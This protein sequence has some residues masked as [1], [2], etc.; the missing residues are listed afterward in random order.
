V[1][2]N[3]QNDDFRKK[4]RFVIKLGRAL[5]GCGAS[6]PRVETHLSNVT[7]MLGLK[8]SFLV[9]PTT[10][11]CAFWQD[12]E[13]DQFIHFE[14][15]EPADHDLGRLWA[16]DAVVEGIEA[17]RTSFAHGASEVER[18]SLAPGHYSQAVNA[19]SWVLIGSSFAALLSNNALDFACRRRPLPADIRL[20]RMWKYLP[21]LN[22]I[23]AILAPFL[24]GILATCAAAA[25]IE[26]NVPFVVLSSIIIYIPGLAL[27]VA[28]SEIAS[29]DL[30]SGTSR[31]MDAVM[32]L[33]KII[34]GAVL[35]MSLARMWWSIP[36]SASDVILAIPSWKTWPAVMGLSLGLSIAFNIPWR[37]TLWGLGSGALAFAVAVAGNPASIWSG[38][39]CGSSRGGA[40]QQSL[41]P[42]DE[43]SRFRFGHPRH[44]PPRARKQNLHDPQQL[45]LRPRY[46]ARFTRFQPGAHDLRRP[47]GRASLRE[48]AAAAQ[49][50]P[51]ILERTMKASHKPRSH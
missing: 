49:Q 28:L 1:I 37:K 36:P 10:L 6:S 44:C 51:L 30:I 16:I 43:G 39:V 18:L 27:T 47:G 48:R 2:V 26:I 29:R 46:C 3:L 21:R 25:G 23:Q 9:T 15:T 32:L 5:H 35:G 20:G 22:P 7:R 8:G 14:R 42:G 24:S 17:G 41:R 12:D 50:E 38:Y 34:F 33:L 31:L 40:L 19:L 11:T 13:M 45:G 4:T